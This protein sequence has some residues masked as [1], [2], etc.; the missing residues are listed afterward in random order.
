M[1]P[2]NVSCGKQR[3]VRN[4]ETLN[5]FFNARPA[6][7]MEPETFLSIFYFVSFQKLAGNT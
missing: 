6:T 2:Q 7:V 5:R 4:K 3:K 1:F